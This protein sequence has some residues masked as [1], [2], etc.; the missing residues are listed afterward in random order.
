MM[1]TVTTAYPKMLHSALRHRLLVITA[2]FAAFAGSLALV[3]SLGV[4]LIPPFAQGEF[5]FQLRL[6]EGSTLA[7]TEATVD[8]IESMLVADPVFARIFSI[9]GSLP[10][11]L[12]VIGGLLPLSVLFTWC[13]LGSRGS[14]LV[15]LLLHTSL[16]VM[17]DLGLA[18]FES[19]A[20]FFF[21]LMAI[22][23][24]MVAVRSPVFRSQLPSQGRSW[25]AS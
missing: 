4:D 21:V 8:R 22:V 12:L 6:P 2:A 9:T 10:A 5:A 23:A 24:M 16:N 3:P 17:G 13:Y 7:S 18:H 1:A 25:E 11:A 20:I 19:A 15:V 14:L